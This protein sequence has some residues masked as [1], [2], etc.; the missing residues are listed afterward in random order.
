MIKSNVAAMM[1]M[2]EFEKI[3]NIQYKYAIKYKKGKQ[4][5]TK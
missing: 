4:N 2:E 5:G 1:T 3:M